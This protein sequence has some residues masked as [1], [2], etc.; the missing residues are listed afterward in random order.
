[1][2]GKTTENMT[3]E[4]P[5]EIS[6]KTPLE[7]CEEESGDGKEVPSGADEAPE[8]SS[9]EGD[10]AEETTETTKTG[11][12]STAG[13]NGEEE[14]CEE[15]KD[16][17]AQIAE[18]E[19][20]L[21]RVYAEMEN[22]RRRLTRELEE[23]SKYAATA[24][25]RDILTATDNLRRALDSIS[26]EAREQDGSLETFAAGVEA[27]EREMLSAFGNHNI[28]KIEPLEEKFNPEFHQAMFE[29]E[30][31]G[32][33]PGTVVEVVQPGYLLHD[34]LLRPAM[35][36]VAKGKPSEGDVDAKI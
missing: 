33:A 19:D 28:R 6:D 3:E 31:T 23:K 29:L 34:R 20:K 22:T 36:G 9:Q 10:P 18:L 8:M 1:M 25:A 30:N 15:E 5:E 13:S 4:T 12:N 16:P 26:P 14:S 2:L 27:I 32:R 21:L 11:V 35:V 24:L 17:K 7:D